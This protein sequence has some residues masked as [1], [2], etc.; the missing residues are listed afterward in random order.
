MCKEPFW[1][2][3]GSP[4]SFMVIGWLYTIVQ[5][6]WFGL[7]TL[8]NIFVHCSVV[9]CRFL[10]ITKHNN[11]GLQCNAQVYSCPWYGKVRQVQVNLGRCTGILHLSCFSQHITMVNKWYKM[12]D[13]TCLDIMVICIYAVLGDH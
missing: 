11:V 9:C 8:T 4:T 5:K 10:V 7:K 12:I 6:S 3:S 2:F 1:K 13:S